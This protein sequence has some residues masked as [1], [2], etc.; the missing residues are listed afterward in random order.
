M[1]EAEDLVATARRQ[2]DEHKRWLT[3]ELLTIPPT[4]GAYL[5][6]DVL[7][8]QARSIE[9]RVVKAVGTT[10]SVVY[11]YP[12]ELFRFLSSDDAPPH[13]R[14]SLAGGH[15]VNPDRPVS[16]VTRERS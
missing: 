11:D 14:A 3:A 4:A 10:V 2:L 13:L 16:T 5:V 9:L 12:D 15:V 8:T 1:S 7:V 6:K